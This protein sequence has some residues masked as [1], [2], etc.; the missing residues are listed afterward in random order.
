MTTEQLSYVIGGTDVHNLSIKNKIL[1][2]DYGKIESEQEDIKTYY[3]NNLN[4]IDIDKRTYE[5]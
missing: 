1:L 4:K 5:N 2:H 3:I